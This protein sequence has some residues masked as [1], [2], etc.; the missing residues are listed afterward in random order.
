[1]TMRP[2]GHWIDHGLYPDFLTGFPLVY[3]SARRAKAICSPL[4]PHGSYDILAS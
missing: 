2:H 3:G 1:M 4:L